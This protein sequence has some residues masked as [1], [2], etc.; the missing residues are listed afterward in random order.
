MSFVLLHGDVGT[1][2]GSLRGP[3][4]HLSGVDFYALRGPCGV[5]SETVRWG[6]RGRCGVLAGS[7]RGKT[8]NDQKVKKRSVWTLKKHKYAFGGGDI[9][10]QLKIPHIWLNQRL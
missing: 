3:I 6:L 7:P 9:A 4:G 1:P 5:Q 10:H 2:A 8:A